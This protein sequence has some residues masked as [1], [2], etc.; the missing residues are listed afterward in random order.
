MKERLNFRRTAREARLPLDAPAQVPPGRMTPKKPQ[1]GAA[2]L[3]L[4]DPPKDS[5]HEA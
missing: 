5:A 4:L 3:P 2:G 1:R